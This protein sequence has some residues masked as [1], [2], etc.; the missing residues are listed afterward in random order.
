MLEPVK[1]KYTVI[2][3]TEKNQQYD[4]SEYISDLSWEEPEKEL[5]A[6][7]SFTA[8]NDKSSKGWISSLAKPGRYIYLM[9]SYNGGKAKEALRGRIIEWNPSAK[10]SSQQLKVKVYDFLYDLQESSD[11]LY[12]KSGTRTKSTISQIFKRWKIPMGKYAGPNV[13]HGKQVYKNKKLGTLVLDVLEEAKK[14]GAD[15][16]F[17]RAVNGKAQVLF[18][19]SNEDVYCFVEKDNLTS[20]SH[21]ITTAGMVTREKVTGE[22]KNNGRTP[23]RATVDGKTKYGIRQKMYTRSKDESL[24]EAKKAAKDILHEDGKPKETIDIKTADIPVIRRGDMVHV[25]MTTGSGFYWVAGISHDCDDMSMEMNLKKAELKEEDSKKSSKGTKS[26]Q[27]KVGEIVEFNGGKHYVSSRK[28]SK[29]YK[30]GAGK[31]KI[32]KVN[33]GSA[34]PWHLVTRNWKKSRVHGWVDDGT[35]K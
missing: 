20:A 10:S 15:E 2:L 14:K 26:G 33:K 3:L 11:N 34:H 9:Y 22:Q 23:V 35:F 6:R 13:K 25:S 19:G 18:Y 7:L 17:V 24:K 12:F 30:A 29:G 28:G 1:Y 16:S 27:H 32:T 31:A 8:K 5:S 21:K 4:I